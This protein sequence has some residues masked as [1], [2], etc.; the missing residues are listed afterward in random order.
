[1][2]FTTDYGTFLRSSHI[3]LTNRVGM[4]LGFIII[5]L[6]YRKKKYNGEVALMCVTWYGAGRMV[7]EGLRTD[8]LYLGN[9]RISQLVAFICFIA[10]SLSS[11]SSA[12]KGKKGQTGRRT[13]CRILSKQLKCPVP[14]NLT[15]IP[16]L[17]MMC[18]RASRWKR[19]RK[20]MKIPMEQNKK[21]NGEG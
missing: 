15:K 8:S 7:I 9:I 14:I 17:K 1:M 4:L 6:Y 16:W 19:M 21:T 3:P 10:G 5:N 20:L 13:E 2:A 11:H 12:C 18:T